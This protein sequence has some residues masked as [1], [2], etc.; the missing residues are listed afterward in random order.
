MKNRFGS[1]SGDFRFEHGYFRLNGKRIYL[2]GA[3][4]LPIYPGPVFR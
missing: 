2:Q 4:I 1:G 3:L